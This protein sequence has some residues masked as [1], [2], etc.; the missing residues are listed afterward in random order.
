MK[1][2]RPP[3][4]PKAL[5]LLNKL[6]E[7]RIKRRNKRLRVLGSVVTLLLLLIFLSRCSCTK[8][9]A[10]P[11]LGP[12]PS[13]A[14]TKRPVRVLKLAPPRSPT[15]NQEK[16]ERSRFPSIKDVEEDWLDEL[17][18]QAAARSHL[19]AD[20]LGNIRSPGAIRWIF[21]VNRVTGETG[22]HLFE[23]LGNT[24]NP[25]REQANCFALVLSRPAFR[26]NL[27]DDLRKNK[28]ILEKRMVPVRVSLVIEF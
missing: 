10:P 19:M 25:D 4:N 1:T 20:C 2:R 13:P 14:A 28:L 11:E 27:P 21:N 9:S 18:S 15:M 3:Q 23:G 5:A 22:E 16:L 17:R 12:A 24:P 7:A 26:F 8:E 6:K